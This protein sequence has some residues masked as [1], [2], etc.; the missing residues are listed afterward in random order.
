VQ[1]KTTFDDV[2][3]LLQLA[4]GNELAFV[5]II[6]RYQ[7]KVYSVAFKFLKSREQA[8]EIVQEVFLRVWN[9]RDA[10]A[11]A[12]NLEALIYTATKNLTLNYLDKI[13]NERQAQYKFTQLRDNVSH[14]TEY[15]LQEREYETLLN[16]SLEELPPQQLLVYQLAKV[17]G[18]SY[19][20]IADRLHITTNTVKYHIK[21]IHKFLRKKLEMNTSL[22]VIP[23]LL[24]I[25]E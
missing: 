5:Q 23:V 11:E 17:E 18:L 9:K 2:E 21:H 20:E 3:L 12:K 15:E 8:K 14:V 13:A 24:K 22:A 25:L 10:F 19:E 4:K 6:D 16:K 7:Q 1:T